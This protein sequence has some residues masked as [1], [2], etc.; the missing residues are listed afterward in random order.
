MLQATAKPVR[1]NQQIW[2][3]ACETVAEG[4]KF[5][6]GLYAYHSGRNNHI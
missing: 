6:K 2:L 3:N 5:F 1:R 4:L